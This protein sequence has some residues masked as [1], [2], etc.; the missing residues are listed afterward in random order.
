MRIAV[1]SRADAVRSQLPALSWF[2]RSLLL[3]ATLALAWTTLQ[4]N[5]LDGRLLRDGLLFFAVPM[6]VAVAHEHRLGWRVDRR[7][8]RNA[9]ALSLFV[10]PFY[11]VGSTLPS[12]R[13]FYPM[14]GLE[15]TALGAFLPHA[16]KQFLLVLAG[17]TFYR[18]LLCVGIRE[19][20]AWVVLISPVVYALH[21][22]GKPPIE[23]A[24]SG[25]TDALFG[26]ADYDAD[27]LLP[28]VCAHGLGLVLLDWLVLH[29]PVI[30]PET[31][32]G[33]LEWLPVPV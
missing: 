15:S 23:L 29:D 27:S 16:T 24:L 11:V 14:W 4:W 21:H 9:L 25:P 7:A 18:G 17:E 28:S 10:L 20:G 26:L 13:A 3:G 32:V 33:W 31:T 22:L 12:V 19:R 5:S 6:A 2:Q 30:D 1:R 8:V